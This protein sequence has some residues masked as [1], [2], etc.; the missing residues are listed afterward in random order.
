MFLLVVLLSIV[1]FSCKDRKNEIS[2][3]EYDDV[4]IRVIRSYVNS[5][6]DSAFYLNN[7]F[8][9]ERYNHDYF[10]NRTLII[11]SFSHGKNLEREISINQILMIQGIVHIDLKMRGNRVGEQSENDHY[12]VVIEVYKI[13]A[14]TIEHTFTYL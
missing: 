1:I 6:K 10:I 14:K 5:S 2:P 9:I 7:E 12:Y 3:I 13:H 8:Y 11:L 4:E